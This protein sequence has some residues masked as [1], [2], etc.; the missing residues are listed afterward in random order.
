MKYFLLIASLLIL[1][2]TLFASQDDFSKSKGTTQDVIPQL[3]SLTLESNATSLDLGEKA[4]LTVTGTYE[5]NS[6][7]ALTSDIEWV[8]IPLDSV[9]VNGTVLTVLKDI[10]TTLQAKVKSIL[11]N[12]LNLELYWEING[13]RLPPEPDPQVNNSTLLGIDSNDNGVRDDVERYIIQTYGK[14]KIII[15]I[16]FQ[17]SRAYDAVI[18]H[19][20]NAWE[21]YKVLDDAMDCE[22]YFRVFAKYLGDPLLLNK[23]EY[24]LTSK[25]FKSIQLNT[26]ERIRG[27]LLHE[28]KLSG[29]VFDSTKISELKSKCSFDVDTLLKARK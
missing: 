24:I 9:D 1:P 8:M 22:S 21:T 7:K 12:S 3:V 14:E 19:P 23:D 13:Y 25:R 11:S 17:V 10:N 15:E 5:D 29:G 18:E 20:E 28:K 26:R 4:L 16:G 2:F 6:T 27:Y